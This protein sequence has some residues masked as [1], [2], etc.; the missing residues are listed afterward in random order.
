MCEQAEAPSYK[1]YPIQWR[2]IIYIRG[3]AAARRNRDL[4]GSRNRSTPIRHSLLALEDPCNLISS[5]ERVI[6][7]HYFI[8]RLARARLG[9]TYGLLRALSEV[10]LQDGSAEHV[11]GLVRKYKNLCFYM[12]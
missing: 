7:L 4:C 12:Q 8:K 10:S 11:G 2:T 6:P 9:R 1:M 3:L 5:S